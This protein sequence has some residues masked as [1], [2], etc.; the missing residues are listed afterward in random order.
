MAFARPLRVKTDK[1]EKARTAM[2]THLPA[3]A[4]SLIKRFFRCS[5]NQRQSV[6]YTHLTLPTKRIV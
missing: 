4:E 3:Q 2:R 5:G 6:S 1:R